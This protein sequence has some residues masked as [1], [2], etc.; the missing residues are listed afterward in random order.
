M[1]KAEILRLGE[2]SRIRI[3]EEEA[4][5]LGADIE[6]VL[7]YVGVINEITAEEG[8]TKKVGAVYNVFREDEIT[9]EQGSHTEALLAEAPSI[10]KGRLE[11]KKILNTD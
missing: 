10:K 9:V 1:N 4:E 5:T 2:L 3:S 6:S 8:V 7:E 11:V